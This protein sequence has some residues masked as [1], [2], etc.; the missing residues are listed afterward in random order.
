MNIR[1]R[2]ATEP[3]AERVVAL[4]EEFTQYLRE[5]GDT[6]STQLTPDIYRRDGF[7]SNPAFFGLVAESDRDMIGYL[8]YH[9]GYDTEI[10]ARVMYVIDL[11]V[12]RD[13]QSKG[14]GTLLMNHAQSICR[15]NR[16]VE[17]L[18][19]VYKMN[20]KAHE[21]YKRFGAKKIDDLD[22]MYLEVTD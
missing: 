10:A 11:Y 4:Y 15:D 9:F 21:F 3:D 5:L 18:W 7:G 14:V 2:T 1:I 16:T 12:S 13:F 19:S 20:P 8:L 6:A 17:M 22:Y